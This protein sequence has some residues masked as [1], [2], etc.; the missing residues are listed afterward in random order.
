M[1]VARCCA[2]FWPGGAAASDDE[3][4]TS[5]PECAKARDHAV[6]STRVS[7]G[8]TPSL[9]PQW[10]CADTHVRRQ[11]LELVRGKALLETAAVPAVWIVLG[12]TSLYRIPFG[13]VLRRARCLVIAWLVASAGVAAAH[14]IVIAASRTSLSL[15]LFVARDQGFFSEVGLEVDLR[16]C[17]G[18]Q[19]C[20]AEVLE[21]RAHLGTASELPV[22]FSAF[23]R[24][25]FAIVATFATTS[26]DTKVVV[27]KGSGIATTSDLAG[28]RIATVRGTSAHYTIDAAL[29]FDGVDP[30]RTSFV[31]LPPEQVGAA[32]IDGRV[33]AAVVWE[34]WAFEL[35]RA[36]GADAVAL[37]GER[38]YTT[39]FNLIASRAWAKDRE[40]DVVAVLRAVQKAVR[41]IDAHP[42]EAMAILEARIGVDRAFI[43]ATWRQ[44]QWKLQLRQSLVSTLEGQVRWALREGHVQANGAMPNMLEFV[45]PTALRKSLPEAA[46][47]V[48]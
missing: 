9:L 4:L 16:E 21:G 27:R 44:H 31:Y 26:D 7:I 45:E 17:L 46:T 25:D 8:A 40:T 12:G 37:R 13:N 11:E 47:L 41:F 30:R 42:A 36:L 38:I 28:R 35:Q 5:A 18:G 24:A 48:K 10:R 15:P 2:S 34:P 1:R 6:Q 33:D 19:R 14:D 23:Q 29:L 20:L 3:G 43:D 39:T 22:A 32:L